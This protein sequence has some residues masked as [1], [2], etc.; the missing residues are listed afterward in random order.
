[1]QMNYWL[2]EVANLAECHTPLFD[3]IRSQLPMWR[4]ATESAKEFST[5]AGKPR[6][7][8]LRTS[9]GIHG[10]LGWKWDKT[11]NAWYGQ[12]LWEHYAFGRDTAY[13]REVAYPILKQTC[14]FWEDQLK[15][16]PDGS[17]VVPNGW[18]PEHGPVE[19]GVSYNQQIVWDLFNNYVEA[20]E[21]LGV[22]EAYRAKVAQMR[23]KL[24][25][26][27]IGKW[28][29][30]QEWMTD[31]DDPKDHHRHTS[32]LFA[33][34]P[35][36]QIGR[37][38]NP[39]LAAAAKKSLEARGDGGDT[40]EWSL[41]WRTSIWARLGDGEKAISQV[42][43]FFKAQHSCPNLFGRHP[44]MQIDGNFGMTA[45]IAEML[46][47]SHENQIV[48]LPAL[49]KD[50]ASGSVKGLR[51]RGGFTVDIE[52]QAGKVIRYRIASPK[53]SPVKVRINDE[54]KTIQ[55]ESL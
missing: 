9:H 22:D 33:V 51:A 53:P 31:R 26:P 47:Q 17:L 32:H 34:H 49:P 35:G 27:K 6:G 19:D 52:W 24:V 10:D 11:A 16:L 4:R 48:L 41:A 21:A 46:I 40:R 18:S 20:S 30:L 43:Q 42:R 28:G 25:G 38:R 23:D 2:A 12:H 29:Q 3:L 15:A 36:R 14:E 55:S 44:P 50:W 39:E 1:V 7:F 54:V 37:E 45:G 5:P 8:A 13:L